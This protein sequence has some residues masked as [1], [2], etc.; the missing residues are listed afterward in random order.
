M[1]NG[2]LHFGSSS[3]TATVWDAPITLAGATN[4]ITSYGITKIQTLEKAIGG[5][6]SLEIA[7]QGGSGSSHTA[8]WT[9]KAAG[10]YTGNTA[11]ADINTLRDITVKLGI[12]NALP[13]TTSLN[14]SAITTVAGSNNVF[15]TLDL[16]GFSQT[17]AG[18]TDT[19]GSAAAGN[20]SSKRVINSIGTLATL[21]INNAA[22]ITYGTTGTNITA[23]TIGGTTDA[24]AG[25]RMA[26][27]FLLMGIGCV[28]YCTF[29]PNYWIDK[30]LRELDTLRLHAVRTPQPLPKTILAIGIAKLCSR[31]FKTMPQP[32]VY[33][34]TLSLM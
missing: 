20:T 6:G 31:P 17:L 14:L 33:A 29:A 9:L 23:G 10:N 4:R 22:A 21:T 26:G 13:T 25:I 16:N 15:A 19:G 2:A 11:I 32:A 30:S 8:T 1:N 18:L 5:T 12:Q 28:T 3:A 27:C 7:S 24:G 34:K